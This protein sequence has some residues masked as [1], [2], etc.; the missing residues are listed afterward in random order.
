MNN[1]GLSP[2]EVET[3]CQVFKGHTEIEQVILFGSRAKGT[4]KPNSDI[5]LAVKGIED[6]LLIEQIA[7]ELDELPLPYKFDLKA[8][9]SINNPALKDHIERVGVMIYKK[10]DF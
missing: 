4:A 2:Q 8:I 10:G 7:T 3:I 1:T 6:D 9:T 5:D